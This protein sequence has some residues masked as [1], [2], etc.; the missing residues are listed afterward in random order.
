VPPGGGP[1]PILIKGTTALHA[2]YEVTTA[3]QARAAVKTIA[4]RQA[5]HLKIWVDDRRGTYPKMPPEVYTAVI[6]EAHR[7]NITV[8]AHATTLADQKA[9]V[10]AGAD[11]LVH[12]TTDPVD[13]ELLSLVRE[14]K[15]YWTPVMGFGDR[16]PA[17][18]DDPFIEQVT[19]ARTMAEIRKTYCGPIGPNVATREAALKANFPAL[20]AAGARLV[21]GTDTGVL[22]R[23]AFGWAQHYEIARY[24]QLGLRPADAIVAATARP[25]ELLGLKDQGTLAVGKNADFLVLNANPLENIRN[26]RQ[27]ASVYVHGVALN[28]DA[29][30]A[31]WKRPA[32]SR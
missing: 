16:S 13:D 32:S 19:P 3:E 10:R 14:R 6:D 23:Y 28:R 21:L 8:H 24:V 11:V 22:P 26:T 7:N 9:V 4:G 2:V 1:D 29:L 12:I 15:P 20:I 30:L 17:C 25:A 5:K 18:E 27:I 31:K